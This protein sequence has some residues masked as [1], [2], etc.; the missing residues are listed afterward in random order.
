MGLNGLIPHHDTYVCGA[1]FTGLV[2]SV[3]SAL[4]G[5]AWQL[6][7]NDEG[8]VEWVDVADGKEVVHSK[9]PQT[10]VWRRF[11]SRISNMN[12]FEGQL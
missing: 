10:S 6:R 12:A 5:A 4:P 7:L 2:E 3:S 9:A 1:G 11:R 8:K